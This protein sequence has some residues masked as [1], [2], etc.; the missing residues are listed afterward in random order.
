MCDIGED[1]ENA[2]RNAS[3]FSVLGGVDGEEFGRGIKAAGRRA[4]AGPPHRAGDFDGA[5]LSS[6]SGRGLAGINCCRSEA[7]IAIPRSGDGALRTGFN[8]LN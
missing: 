8:T 3:H 5:V 2:A 7:W 6:L 1:D 4:I